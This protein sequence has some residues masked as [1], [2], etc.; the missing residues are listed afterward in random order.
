MATVSW[1]YGFLCWSDYQ[2]PSVDGHC[3]T[4]LPEMKNLAVFFVICSL[5]QSANK[6]AGN[7]SENLTKTDCDIVT[8]GFCIPKLYNKH[9]QPNPLETTNVQVKFTVEQITAVDDHDFT[10]DLTTFLSFYWRD[11]RLKYIGP[12]ET[13]PPDIPLSNKWVENIWLPDI[14]VKKMKAMKKPRLLQEFGSK[15]FCQALK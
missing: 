14:F 2:P 13:K 12:N 4:Q 8:E 1:I 7:S 5:A 9:Q 10:I 11:D 15:S 6:V 3:F